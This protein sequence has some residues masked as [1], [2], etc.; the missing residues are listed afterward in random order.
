MMISH[1]GGA[2]SGF[3]LS[4]L[5]STSFIGVAAAHAAGP[6]AVPDTLQ[7]VP[8]TKDARDGTEIIV[9]GSRASQQSA[10]RRKKDAKTATDSLVADDIG[11]FP[12]RNVNEAISRLPGV[13]LDR[14]DFGEGS[15][16]AI[17]GNGPDL[18]RVELDGIGVQSTGGLDSSRGADLRELPAELIKS[19]DVV[20]GS[21]ADMTEGSLGGGVQIK[22]RSGLDFAKPYF[23]VRGGAQMNTISNRLTPDVSGVAGGKLFNGLLGVILSGSY[24]DVQNIG[25]TSDNV[26]SG[27]RNYSRLYDFDQ[28]P[29]KTFTYNL[30]SLQSDGT[31]TRFSN[32]LETPRTLLTK[33]IAAASKA[34]C[35]NL[36]PHNPTGS[37]AVRSQRIL[38]QQSCLNQWNDYTPSLIRNIMKTQREKRYSV[39][40]RVD[41]RVTNNLTVFAKGTIANR[42]NADQFRTRNSLSLFNANPAGSFV[43]TTTGYPRFRTLASN[44]PAGYAL[45][46]PQYG[47]N[48]VGSNATFGNVLNVVPSS[49]VVDANHN[50]TKMTLTNNSVGIDQIQN[51]NRIRTNYFQGGAN[52]RG[53]LV[54]IEAMAGITNTNSSR[55]DLRTSR[56]YVYG[57]AT[58]ELQK[59]GLWDIQLPTNYD[60]SN[61]NNFVQLTAPRCIVANAT[62]PNCIGQAAVVASASGP[63]TPAYTV[64][65]LPLTTPS[66]QVTFRP[67][68]SEQSERIGKLD[69][70]Y[71]TDEILPFITRV[72]YGAMYRNNRIDY[73]GAGGFEAASAIGTFGQP[74]YIPA[75]VVPTA[76]VT[77]SY[78]ACQPTAG[79]SASGGLSCNYGFVPSSNPINSRSGVDTLTPDQLRQLFTD[80]LEKPDSQYFNSLPNR[81]NLPSSWPGILT[82][83]MFEQ[84]GAQQFINYDCVKQCMGTDGQMYDQP[85]TRT[86]ETIINLYG[87]FDFSQ[88]LPWGFEVDGNVGLR[89]IH[90]NVKGSGQLVLNVIRINQFF[91]PLDPT[92][93]AGISSR[94]FRQNT[95]ARANSWNWLPTGNINLWALDRTLV[96]RAYRGKT[97]SRPRPDQLLAAA[98][99]VIDER[100]TLDLDGD[101]EELFGCSGTRVGNPALRPFTAWNTNLSLEWYPN[102]DTVLSATYGKLDVKLGG[103][104]GETRTGRPFVGSTQI[105]P[106]TGQPLSELEFN[107]P[108]YR[109]GPG[110]KRSI[111]EF[112]AKSAFTFLPWYFRYTGMDAN[113]SRLASVASSGTQ[114]PLTADIMPPVNESRYYI[115]SSLWYDDGKLSMRVAYQKRSSV[116]TCITPCGGNTTD[117]NYPG[118]NWSNVRLVGPGYNPGTPRYRDETQFVDAKIA[119]NFTPQFQ[120]YVEGRNVLG[121]SQTISTGDYAR[122]EDGTP[123]VFSL[124]YGG[125][126]I[127]FG[128]R[129]AFGNPSRQ[130]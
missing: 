81:G 89:G 84:L 32:S 38:E 75:V 5:L 74:G 100:V 24:A 82:D 58:I 88:K 93:A 9:T 110:Y 64:G 80:T 56:S 59:N 126:R 42:D 3:T 99:C 124:A 123:R 26:T 114:D 104:I 86:N 68:I 30:D 33:S 22:T 11:S 13:A 120:I 112:S 25:H 49:V 72:K 48:S 18:T 20:K 35:I 130:R 79:S 105:D 40:A 62:P 37:T 60:D 39:D 76:N 50:V 34:D 101:G 19:V 51:D 7:A 23:T 127:L 125:R 66:F 52:F 87:M 77:G 31:D 43:D 107:Y 41:L 14:N 46:D 106:V 71:R 57:D 61:P 55:N 119:Y 121:E 102:R 65:Q 63:A 28:S 44:A 8:E 10:N 91:N 21:T 1:R 67:R 95:T 115:N 129:L 128:G 113:L 12:D 117:I 118:L 15:A 108:T 122:F 29:E 36:F 45:F 54:D 109:N 96:F 47:L 70:T 27:N 111:W 4:L 73:W 53:K 94:F 6:N 103:G 78:R 116:F 17:R 98:N 90:T 2:L 69:V 16:I 83:K 92:Q 85:V 97:V